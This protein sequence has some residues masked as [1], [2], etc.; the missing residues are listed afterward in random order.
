LSAPLGV[1]AVITG[2]FGLR[3]LRGSRSEGRR[4]AIAGISCGTGSVLVQ[5]VILGWF[6]LTG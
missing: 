6:V 1:V 2:A 5:M 4:E 3:E